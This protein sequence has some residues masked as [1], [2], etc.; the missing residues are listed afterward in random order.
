ML[1]YASAQE[2]LATPVEELVSAF[3]T[4]KEDGTP[5]R[6]EDLPGRQLLAGD[7]T[8]KPLVVRAVDKRT[9]EVTWRVTK[10]SGV[11]DA[12]GAIKLVVN[13]IQDLTE[14]KRAELTQRM[15]A[16]AG[17]LLS[18]SLDYERTLQQ[19]AELAVP[20]LA[21]W[22]T[23]SLPDAHG[24]LRAVAV[25]HVDAEKVAFARSIGERYPT[26]LDAPT[27]AAQ[28][29]RD[30]VP[31]VVNDVTDEMLAAAAQDEEHLALLRGVGLR[32]GLVVP[33]ASGGAIVGALTLISAESGRRFNDADVALA[34][35]LARRAGTAVENARLYTERSN[36]ARTLQT[37]LLP[38][39]LPRMPGWSAAT[40]YRAAGDENWVGGD[41]YDAIEVEGGWLAIVGDVAGRGAPAAALTGLA[42]H[43]LR[44]AATLL[45]DPL[46]AVGTLNDELL[47][48]EE[49]SL[50]SVAA[51]AAVRRRREGPRRRRSSAPAI[52]CRCS[53]G[54]GEVRPIGD[55]SPP[56][57]ARTRST[58]GSARRS[59]WSPA[60]CSCCSP[61]GCSTPSVR[62]SASGGAPGAHAAARPTRRTPWPHRRRAERVRGRRTGRRHR[63]PGV[64]RSPSRRHPPRSA[65]RERST[66]RPTRRM[67]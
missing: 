2:L 30:G 63:R 8:P 28:V 13:V 27:G 59:S 3:D 10:A 46:D 47:A 64:A 48:R 29:V 32:G 58:S 39:R 19:V 17:E 44:T 38:G 22:C 21:D 67:R 55:G 23:V 11:Y 60:T 54:S 18:S 1:G 31:Q 12:D 5:L 34:E 49:M 50:C 25:A 7:R 45:D 61:T 33:M 20:E 42:R 6:L 66:A 62:S 16:R 56:C 26:P 35:E 52:R 51:R 57:S 65:W 43:T 36:I 37:S 41:F 24:F 40:L 14:V 53:C 4:T 9:G 15:L